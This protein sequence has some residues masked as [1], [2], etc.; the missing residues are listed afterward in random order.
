MTI[1]RVPAATFLTLSISLAAVF[2]SEA[3]QGIERGAM[4][5]KKPPAY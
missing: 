5:S 1:F 4:G 3:P 2:D